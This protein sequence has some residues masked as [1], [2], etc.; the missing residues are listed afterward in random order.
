[1][2][3]ISSQAK[4]D[5]SSSPSVM[6]EDDRR[7]LIAR[8]HR[9]LYGN[10]GYYDGGKYGEDGQTPRP[11]TQGSTRGHSPMAFNNFGS[12]DVGGSADE[13]N[14]SG[15]SPKPSGPRSRSNSNSSPASA[16]N[17]QN[18]SSLFD[19]AANPHQSSRTSTSSPGGSPPRQGKA[20]APA[21][22]GT[23]P[24][25]PA[26]NKRA[27]PPAASPLSFGF[28]SNDG[29]NQGERAGSSAS[30]PPSSAKENGSAGVNWG[31]GSGVWGQ[32]K[33]GGVQASVWG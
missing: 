1:M 4:T 16:S 32:G 19:Q 23:R 2:A 11:I 22:I 13:G 18:Y 7:D 10:D 28:A 25:N 14:K 29:A 8:Q 31:S 24:T 12:S 5:R 6:N 33:L 3:E 20:N 17:A 21:P 26:L 9:A 30:N 15:P 27:T